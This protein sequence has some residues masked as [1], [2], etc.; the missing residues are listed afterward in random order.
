MRYF[1][2]KVKQYTEI[3]R[4]QLFFRKRAST[5]GRN[6]EAYARYIRKVVVDKKVLEIGTDT[7]VF[8]F[9]NPFQPS[10]PY[11]VRRELGSLKWK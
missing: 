11:I 2:N 3:G 7:Y 4:R 1:V 9:I 6:T 10:V 8:S 5:T